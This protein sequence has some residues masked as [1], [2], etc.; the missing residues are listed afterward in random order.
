MCKNYNDDDD[1][2]NDE[3][4]ATTYIQNFLKKV[5]TEDIALILFSSF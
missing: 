3:Y 2:K 5:V 4:I 1:D